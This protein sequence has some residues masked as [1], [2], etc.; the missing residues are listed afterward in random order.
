[1]KVK[2]KIELLTEGEL[3][4]PCVNAY[5]VTLRGE[6]ALENGRMTPGTL[7]G[8]EHS[9][10]CYVELDEHTDIRLRLTVPPYSK[11]DIHG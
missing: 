3:N 10:I 11:E 4:T 1:M 7:A 6:R 2:L 5:E 8:N 9:R